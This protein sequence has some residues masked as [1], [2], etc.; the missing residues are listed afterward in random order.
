MRWPATSERAMR[1]ISGTSSPVAAIAPGV[2][3]EA[4]AKVAAGAGLAT[5]FAGSWRGQ[6]TWALATLPAEQEALA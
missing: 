2:P 1:S 5:D 4:G 6:P 3:V